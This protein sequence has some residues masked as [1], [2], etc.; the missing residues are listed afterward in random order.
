VRAK[1]T[2]LGLDIISNSPAEFATAIATETPQWATVIKAA[3]IRIS[4]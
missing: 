4:E 3:G 2:E 1:L